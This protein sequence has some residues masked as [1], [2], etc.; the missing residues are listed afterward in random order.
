MY[1]DRK[2]I[3]SD[4]LLVGVPN[5]AERSREC[6]VAWFLP[7]DLEN[8]RDL[9]PGCEGLFPFADNGAGDQF[10]V[11]LRQADPEVIY[12]THEDGKS[13]GLGVK[14]SAFLAAPR[15]KQPDE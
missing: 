3:D 6:Y 7:A 8:S 15:R 12:H 14:L 4:D 2:L 13:T 1:Q 9:W 10:L 5:P 11:D